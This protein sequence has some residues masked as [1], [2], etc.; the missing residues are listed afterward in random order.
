MIQGVPPAISPAPD[1]TVFG[2][3]SLF[4]GGWLLIGRAGGAAFA[5]GF[6]VFVARQLQPV[7][8]G[9][10]AVLLGVATFAGV[11]AEGGLPLLVVEMVGADPKRARPI[12][13]RAL[14]V[15]AA[16]MSV[17]IACIVA[18]S[19]LLGLGLLTGSFY[20][21]AM[22][23]SAV[24][25]TLGGSLRALGNVVPEGLG[26]LVG[27]IVTLTAGIPLLLWAPTPEA[28][29]AAYA[30]GGLAAMLL[31]A[32]SA[33]RHLPAPSA[34]APEATAVVF[35]AHRAIRLTTHA[36]LVT[37]YN[38]VDLWLLAALSTSAT[39]GLYAAAYRFYEGL[40]LPGTTVGLLLA[41]AGS[42][43]KN[44]DDAV[45]AYRRYVTVALGISGV[46]A[47]AVVA[48]SRPLIQELFGSSYSG[49]VPAL[50][51]LCAASFPATILSVLSP[52]TSLR[53]PRATTD[54]VAVGIVMAALL[55]L[56]LIPRYGHVGAATAMLLCQ[57]ALAALVT[58]RAWSHLPAAAQGRLSSV[59]GSAL[60]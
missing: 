42:R 53:D 47:I 6:L 37:L 59:H 26:E 32:V 57:G 1:P 51:L 58:H 38:R 25:T 20:G 28:V 15:R 33:L 27:R 44:R 13:R 17:G 50:R 11:V 24:Q 4:Q 34:E 3:S 23:F 8:F 49:A 46:G 7:T 14:L 45:I 52:I 10:L 16:L 22:L 54:V 39:V 43:T 29:T 9:T 21:V 56:A 40:V 60:R 55:N 2:R 36:V 5:A 19:W 18:L 35:S 30:V 41:A 12:V 48:V 31:L